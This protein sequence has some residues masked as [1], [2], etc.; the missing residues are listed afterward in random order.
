M[1]IRVEGIGSLGGGGRYDKLVGMFLGRDIP[2]C[3]FSLGLERIIVVMAE[4][5]LFPL[6][7]I[8]SP[9]DVMVCMFDEESTPYSMELSNELRAQGL[10]VLVQPEILNPGKQLMYARNLNI[11]FMIVVGSNERET[12]KLILR[13]TKIRGGEEHLRSGIAEVIKAQLGVIR[14]EEEEEARRLSFDLELDGTELE[15]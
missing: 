9:A 10:H 2:A 7:L 3:G 1:E 14:R 11:P 13:N 12:G 5:K 6:S 15:D 8:S 4:Q